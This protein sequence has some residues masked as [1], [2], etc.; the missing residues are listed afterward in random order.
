MQ[1]SPGQPELALAFLGCGALP[2]GGQF[3][4]AALHECSASQGQEQLAGPLEDKGAL[5]Q[6]SWNWWDRPAMEVDFPQPGRT[7]SG[8]S[9]PQNSSRGQA[10]LRSCSAGVQH[11]L[12]VGVASWASGRQGSTSP[13]QPE[14]A[15]P[16]RDGGRCP[17][18]GWSFLWHFWAMELFQGAGGAE[19][20]LHR[21]AAPLEGQ[22]G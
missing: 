2:G 9:G 15:G 10:V 4:V 19:Q 18:A 21:S 11:L 7:F 20:L 16:P 17:M 1:T 3:W 12:R 14:L 6:G 5:H 8:V 22:S 13:E